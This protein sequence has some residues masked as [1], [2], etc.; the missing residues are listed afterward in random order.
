MAKPKPPVFHIPIGRARDPNG[1][2]VLFENTDE[3]AAATVAMWHD[4][5]LEHPATLAAGACVIIGLRRQ[6]TW[7]LERA[8]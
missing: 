3:D 8:L 4:K 5:I 1:E 6:A 2:V 7:T